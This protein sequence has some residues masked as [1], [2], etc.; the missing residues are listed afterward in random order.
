MALSKYRKDPTAD[1]FLEWA[2]NNKEAFI[3]FY[4]DEILHLILEL[5]Q[6][7]YF[8]TEGFDKRFA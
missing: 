4:Y 8:G 3:M 6:D 5:E 7:D 1:D 2:A